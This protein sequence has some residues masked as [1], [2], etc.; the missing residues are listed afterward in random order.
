MGVFFQDDSLTVDGVAFTP[1]MH[2]DEELV[3]AVII[4]LF[5]WRRALP[6]DELPGID[7]FGWWGDT[8]P[9][10]ASDRIGSRLWLLVRAKLTDETVLRARDYAIEALQWM[11]EDGVA[12]RVDVEAERQGI[13]ML[14][15]KCVIYRKD[16]EPL[17]L[18]FA[19]VWRF[20]ANAV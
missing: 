19:D 11:I 2:P 14:A 16:A 9:N 10:V 20:I 3:R 1:N 13:N 4:S 12:A 8:F 17:D 18:R 7:R 6:D 5:T 15:I